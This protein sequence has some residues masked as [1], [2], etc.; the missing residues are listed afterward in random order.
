MS[1][2]AI[3]V[4]GTLTIDDI[5]TP[6]GENKGGLGGSATYFTLVARLF[7][8]VQVVGAVGEADAERFHEVL[9]DGHPVDLSGLAVSKRPTFRW[10][11][12]HDF[13]LGRT[14]H[15]TAYPGA[16][17]EFQ[18]VVPTT[19][20]GAAIAFIGSMLPPLQLAVV[21]QLRGRS[22]L[23][24]GDTMRVYAQSQR[25]L[26]TRFV[27]ELD[28]LIVNES[29]AMALTDEANA[30]DAT[31]RLLREHVRLAWIVI[32]E[33]AAGATLYGRTEKVHLPA[34]LPS[35]QVVDP[36]GAGDAVAGALLGYL[37]EQGAETA[38][39]RTMRQALG[40]GMVAASFAIESFSIDRLKSLTR[41][42]IE[43][44][45]ELYRERIREQV[46]R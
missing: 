10:V 34:F 9:A 43:E 44:R 42:A 26:V 5:R 24:V 1:R 20:D 13:K 41:S 21:D 28:L 38:D 29:E 32:K 31:K 12:Q 46:G 27:S 39:L 25:E 17:E 6:L 16:Y 14:A 22:R 19:A 2:N 37:S 33:G 7:A 23:V 8:S 40:Y 45:M 18:P 3:L 30:E 36:T 35:D 4:A 11:A 15:E